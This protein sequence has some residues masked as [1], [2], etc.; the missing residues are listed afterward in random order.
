MKHR[1]MACYKVKCRILHILAILTHIRPVREVIIIPFY[2][3]LPL[4]MFLI[5]NSLQ[6]IRSPCNILFCTLVACNR[7]EWMRADDEYRK[8]I[9][10]V[11]SNY[12]DEIEHIHRVSWKK[13][14]KGMVQ[15]VV[16]SSHVSCARTCLIG[17]LKW[18]NTRNARGGKGKLQE[19]T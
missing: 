5:A 10:S 19:K 16:D 11:L 3:L 8:L 1:E 7:T 17:M 18:S 12:A 9:Y 15:H 4:F 13:Y 14:T 2:I 6:Q